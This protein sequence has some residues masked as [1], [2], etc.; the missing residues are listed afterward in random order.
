MNLFPSRTLEYVS[1]LTLPGTFL[2][3]VS[4][5]LLAGHINILS[6]A[7]FPFVLP[8]SLCFP[9]VFFSFFPCLSALLVGLIL[10]CC[11]LPALYHAHASLSFSVLART[12]HSSVLLSD[13]TAILEKSLVLCLATHTHTHSVQV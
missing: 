10:L 1:L 2:T 8:F 9:V 11:S 13:T 6:M 7:N 5:R 4:S 3:F 12:H